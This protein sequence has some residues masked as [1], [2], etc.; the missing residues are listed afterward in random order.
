MLHPI[1]KGMQV[2][3]GCG[4]VLGAHAIGN[5][6]GLDINALLFDLFTQLGIIG[7]CKGMSQATRTQ[8]EGKTD[9]ICVMPAPFTRMNS[10]RNT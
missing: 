5:Q 3:S 1:F 2:I 8:L 9:A 6:T 7:Y 10:R 4:N